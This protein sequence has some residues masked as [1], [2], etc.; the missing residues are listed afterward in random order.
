MLL[1]GIINN[2]EGAYYLLKG[3][4]NKEKTQRQDLDS[5]VASIEATLYVIYETITS[6]GHY[7][8]PT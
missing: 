6:H 2:C 1:I 3:P 5:K 8:V 4:I 7:L